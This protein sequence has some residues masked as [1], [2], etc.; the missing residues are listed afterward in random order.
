MTLTIYAVGDIML[1][2]HPLRYNFGVG[3][4]IK[5]KGINYLFKEIKNIFKDGDIVFGNLEAPISNYTDKKGFEAN[6]FRANPNIIEGLKNANFNVLSVANNHIMEHGEKAFLSTVNTLRENNITPVGV[7]NRKDIFDFRGLKIAFLGYSFIEDFIDNSQYNKISS[8]EKVLSDIKNLRKQVDLILISLHWGYEYV[9]FP[10]P[11]QIEIGRK[12]IDYGVDLIL[13]HHAHVIQ[14]LEMYRGKLIVYGLGNFIFDQM[15]YIKTTQKSIIAKIVVDADKSINVD[16][17]P[18]IWDY[19]EN[20]PAIANKNDR[21]EILNRI[22]LVRD[23][24]EN[25]SLSNYH[26]EIGDYPASANKYKKIAK[27]EMKKQFIKNLYKYPPNLSI[28]TLK[29]YL[30]KLFR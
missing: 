18:I 4:I 7:K 19:N 1:G 28:R 16:I 17:I 9:P 8:E 29:I 12:L 3:K 20:C 27:M 26:S 22:S 10:S 23:K 15:T 6:F 2:E 24:I 14:G 30:Q 13:G 5:D 25:K 21:D 11:E